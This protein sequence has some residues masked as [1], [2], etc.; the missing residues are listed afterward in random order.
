MWGIAQNINAHF[1]GLW[2]MDKRGG[3][4]HDMVTVANACEAYS[5][6]GTAIHHG[7]FRVRT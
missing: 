4:D 7:K 2:P 3:R 1:F 6:C 5:R